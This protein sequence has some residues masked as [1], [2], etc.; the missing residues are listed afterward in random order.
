MSE[1][2]AASATSSI[3]GT[4][5]AAGIVWNASAVAILA[6]AGLALNIIIGRWYGPAVLGTFNIAFAIYIFMSQIAVF[7]LQ[8]SALQLT[9]VARREDPR[10]FAALVWGGGLACLAI[11][12]TV[13]VAGLM[14]IPLARTVFPA[15]PDLPLAWLCAAPGLLP[16]A[17]NKYLL[18]VVNGMQH[19]RAFAVFQ[20]TRFLLILAVLVALAMAS[21][22]GAMLTLALSISEI[23]LL[24]FLVGYAKR[25]LR[26]RPTF[27]E[28][29]QAARR[30]LAFGARVLPA[31]L[32]AE[33]NT[34]VDVLMLGFYLGDR[35]VGVYTI[36]ALIY[37]MALQAVV[38]LRNN[39][40][41]RIARDI[42]SGGTGKLLHESRLVALG[43]A[44]A[45]AA[46]GFVAYHLFPHVAPLL[47]S[48]KDFDGAHE[49][50]FY[51]LLSLPFAAAPLCY[52]L[53]LSQGGKPGWQSVA[54]ISALVFNVAMS[55]LLIPMYGIVGAA[56]AMGMSGIF[57]GI[58][59]VVLARTVLGIRLF[60]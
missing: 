9:S 30:H 29:L 43:M 25:Q 17:L 54:M 42:A 13:T 37:E 47:F 19:M 16:F 60:L 52:A 53:V 26:A 59:C 41:P 7:G 10:D 23:I 5:L 38:V 49:P 12:S 56:V 33:L 40:N 31:G 8:L 46:G 48:G 32:V 2:S 27:P 4:G 1:H 21:V 34:R 57:M 35:A 55:A 44:A 50:L 3:A 6:L 45:M 22:E 24:V 28:T 51:L 39:L 15:A 14:L 58:I 18:G 36:A 20:A 11:A